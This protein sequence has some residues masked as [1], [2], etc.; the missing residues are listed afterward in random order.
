M[1]APSSEAQAGLLREI[2]PL[3]LHGQAWPDWVR[4]LAWII[5]AVIGVQAVSTVIRMPPETLNLGFAIA[6]VVVFLAVAVVCWHMQVSDTVIE[7][8]G[9]RQSWFTRREV[10]WED[11]KDARYMPLVFSKRLVVF[12]HGG[13]PVVFQGGT[14]E[15]Q[16][17]FAKISA[18]YRPVH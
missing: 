17:A 13:R 11:I 2:G 10:R 14:K 18:L 3:P 8:H 15:L 6:M 12:T 7:E 16:Q 4:I 5:L 1:K 9:L